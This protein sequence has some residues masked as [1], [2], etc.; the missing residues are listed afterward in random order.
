MQAHKIQSITR[1]KYQGNVLNLEVETD[2]SYVTEAFI[3][4]NCD[5][6]RADSAFFDRLKV[7]H[8]ISTVRQAHRESAGV[9]YWVDYQPHHRYGIGADTSEGIGKDANTMALWDFGSQQNDISVLGATY[10]NNRIPPDLFGHELKRVGQEFGNCII[11]PEA[12]NTGHATIAAMRG[13]PNI[14]TE[15]K[16]GNR[17]IKHTERLGW[18]TTK[19][20][21]PQMLFEFR[22]DYNDGL[23]KIYDINVLK[24]MR[25]Y[26]TSDLNDTQLGLVTRHFDL[27]MA[28]VIGYQMKKYATMSYEEE[29]WEEDE[30]LYSAIGI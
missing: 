12:N 19:K 20:S 10:F 30:P 15:R 24:E 14:F 6:S 9:K 8:D 13:Y 22:K 18:R 25:S 28:V 4:H 16:E 5:P 1:S 17:T 7:D 11:A 21:K 26:T 3:V 2:N 27:F 23:I 29:D